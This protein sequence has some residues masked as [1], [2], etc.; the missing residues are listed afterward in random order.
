MHI[1]TVNIS[2]FFKFPFLFMHFGN[3]SQ[4]R[5]ILTVS[6]GTPVIG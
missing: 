5:L 1:M 6:G 4:F 2:F 3:E